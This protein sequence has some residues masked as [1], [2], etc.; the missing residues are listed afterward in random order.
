MIIENKYDVIAIGG[1]IAN[2]MAILSLLSKNRNLKILMLEKGNDINKRIC[3]KEEFGKCIK[4]KNC[5]IF[6]LGGAG[7]FSDSKLSY[8]SDIGGN[9]IDYIGE[10]N[11]KYYLNEADKI[12]T[13]FGGNEE[14][15]DNDEYANKLSYEC[16]KYGLKLIKSKFR[17]L[18]TDGSQE[19][20]KNIYKYL[21]DFS[22]LKIRTNA[23]VY[24]VN[25]EENE[26]KYIY[27]EEHFKSTGNN[28]I[29]GVGRSGSDWLTDL[30]KNQDVKVLNNAI[31]I[32]VRVECPASITDE[33]TKELYEFKIVNYSDTDNKVRSFCVNPN[34]FVTNE[35][36]D[37]GIVCVNGHSYLNKKSEN[38]NFALL[39][40]CK[41]TEP[42]NKPIKFG[43]TLCSYVN[44]LTNGKV[45]VQRL[46]DL[47]N[48]KRSTK[49]RIKR[50]SIN[51]TLKD[52]EP[53]DLRYALPSNILDSIIQ[54]LDNMS[55]VIPNLNGPNTI[56]Y[57]PEVKFYSALIDVDN[58]L[59]LKKYKNIY[60]IGDSSGITHGIMQ[61]S[62]SGLY[63][64]NK[65]L[66]NK[67]L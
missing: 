21:N 15:S 38:T 18:G 30:C 35:N 25:F 66:E 47:K 67:L 43:K 44:M 32:G 14:F 31:D 63:V 64:A 40:S 48:K 41:F 62:I 6:G 52:A 10:D 37:D 16:S 4:C 5:Y 11:F 20:M 9:I 33:I 45:M 19:V 26:V 29:I 49:D 28:I 34:G 60:C 59:Q 53:G 58:N 36:Y 39:V 54:T 13:K 55:N 57:A 2:T 1:G 12:F 17:H 51:P 22:N 8:S 27:N 24:D 65:I 46:L 7:T 42:F 23:E 61:S 3:P 56:L 50:L